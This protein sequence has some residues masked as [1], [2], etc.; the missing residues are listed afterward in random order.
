M[1]QQRAD[2][3]YTVGMLDFDIVVPDNQA[4]GC[5]ALC[6]DVRYPEG[7]PGGSKSPYPGN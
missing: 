1:S 7:K 5:A 2:G 6:S 4:I 3:F